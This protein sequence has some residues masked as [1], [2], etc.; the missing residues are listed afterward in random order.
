MNNKNYNKNYNEMN[1][2][3]YKVVRIFSTLFRS[4]SE[5]NS[6]SKS[7]YHSKS[8]KLT[9]LKTE[10]IDINEKDMKNDERSFDMSNTS[11]ILF[12]EGI[13]QFYP[14]LQ[15][16]RSNPRAVASAPLHNNIILNTQSNNHTT[17]NN[18]E[19]NNKSNN[20]SN[21][22]QISNQERNNKNTISSIEVTPEKLIIHFTSAEHPMYQFFCQ[23]LEQFETPGGWKNLLKQDETIRNQYKVILS[24]IS[25]ETPPHKDFQ[26]DDIPFILQG[27]IP[28]SAKNLEC[29]G[30]GF[31]VELDREKFMNYVEFTAL[32]QRV[33]IE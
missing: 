7:Q 3:N 16:A 10:T 30:G 15:L 14:L 12:S 6:C 25:D 33:L 8:N 18:N 23:I 13:Q 11:P 32:V 28:K 31:V 17:N 9:N 29:I 4:I 2:K 5:L 24:Q 19:S 21:I 22:I 20:E 26:T 27:L 1:N